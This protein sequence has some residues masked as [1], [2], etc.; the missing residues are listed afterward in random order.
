MHI[1][2]ISSEGY[3]DKMNCLSG[4]FQQHQA[5]ILREK[6]IQ[7]G[8]LTYPKFVSIRNIITSL[9]HPL[10]FY[11]DFDGDIPVEKFLGWQLLPDRVRTVH[12][13][14]I[15][16]VLW[17]LVAARR[18][19]K[20]YGM[21]DIIH[22]HNA[23]FAGNLGLYLKR[24][25]KKPLVITEHASIFLAHPLLA[26]WYKSILKSYQAAD[27]LLSVSNA[28]GGKLMNIFGDSG[29]N[30]TCVPNVIDSFFEVA[31][32]V[33]KQIS[34]R[35][36][37]FLHIAS[38][39]PVKSQEI[40]LCAFAKVFQTRPD[41]RLRIGGEGPERSKLES[42]AEGLSIKEQVS[43]LGS[44]SREQALEEMRF[45]DAFVLSSEIETFGV[46]LIEALTCGKPVVSTA[47]GGPNEIVNTQNGELVPVMDVDALAEALIKMRDSYE[48]YDPVEIRRDCIERFGKES[49]FTQ[50]NGIYNELAE[51]NEKK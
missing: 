5:R 29:K 3:P 17:G 46:V 50:L 39:V 13:D 24:L 48:K 2:I 10:G 44:L 43:F 20:K 28:L 41:V 34:G 51:K 26:S 11:T 8:I 14:Q 47:C 32:L 21:P 36:F 18:Y 33:Q 38:L 42:L 27:R 25:W 9:K 37:Q 4:I 12:I 30:W 35:P 19:V 22:A 16:G 45:C 31:P 6:K 49:F 40:L 7:V 23:Q 15:Q 1:L